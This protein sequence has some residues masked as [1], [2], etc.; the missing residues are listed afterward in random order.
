MT[1]VGEITIQVDTDKPEIR[2][3]DDGR[4]QWRV[5][6]HL[7]GTSHTTAWYDYDPTG[8]T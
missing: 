3:L 8:A 5:T 4:I 2:Y 7:G 1:S 6:Y